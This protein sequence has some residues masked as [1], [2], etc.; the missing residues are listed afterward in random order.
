L[1][2]MTSVPGM[3]VVATFTG[4]VTNVSEPGTLA[5]LVVGLAGLV[6]ARRRSGVRV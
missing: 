6:A 3:T 2:D 5:L 4:S 1:I